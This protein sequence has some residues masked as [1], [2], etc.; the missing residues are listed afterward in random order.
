[1]ILLD[2][3]V[4]I[5]ILDRQSDVGDGL[6]RSLAG[7]GEDLETS[8]TNMHELLY[9]L[10]RYSKS[11]AKVTQPRVLPYEKEEAELSSKLELAAEKRGAPV[12]RVDS[13][14]AAIA[15]N[16]SARLSTLDLGHFERFLRDGLKLFR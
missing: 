11:G 4:L 5:E 3:D 1:L 6:L 8:S 15:V 9:G 13:M 2:T 7:A 10:R 16:R 12:P 14:I